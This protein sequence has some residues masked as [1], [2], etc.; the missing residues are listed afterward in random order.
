MYLQVNQSQFKS[1]SIF[2]HVVIKKFQPK[3]LKNDLIET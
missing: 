3:R 2:I 1:F